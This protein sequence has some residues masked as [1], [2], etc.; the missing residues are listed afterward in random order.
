MD[1]NRKTALQ[2]LTDVEKNGSY[3]NISL[4]RHIKENA[5]TDPAFVREL[6][7]GVI[8]NKYLLDHYLK[9]FIHKGFNKLRVNESCILRMGAYQIIFMDSVPGYAACSETVDLA[10]KFAR[11]KEG[12]INGVLRSLDRNRDDLKQPESDDP[13]EYISIRYSVE[14]WIAELLISI[15]GYEKAEKYM[16]AVNR[17]PELCLRTNLLKTDRESLMAELAD[18][19]FEVWPSDISERAL[20]VSGTGIGREKRHDRGRLLRSP[21]WKDRSYRGINGRS[22]RDLRL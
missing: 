15:Y 16:E 12:F 21:G 7:Y 14:K 9:Q 22:G 18:Q 19:G 1:I 6:V 20:I 3:S 10:K 5:A 8:K 13:A 2:V 11:G 17:S 4:N